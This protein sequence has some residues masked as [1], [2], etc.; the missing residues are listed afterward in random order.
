MGKSVLVVAAH[1]DDE[2][3]GCGA[4]I[5]KHV[6]SGD[7]VTIIFMTDGVGSRLADSAQ[8]SQRNQAKEKALQVLGVATSYQF[9][10]PDNAMD[11]VSLFEVVRLVEDVIDKVKPQIIYTHFHG[12]VN[13][14]H[15]ICFEA[16]M[17]ATRPVPNQCVKEIY[18]FEV[19]S[20]TEWQIKPDV[21]FTPQMY[22]D[23]SDCFEDKKI[24]LEAYNDEM[25][26][27]PHSRSF[28]HVEILGQHRGHTVGVKYAEAFMT[29]RILKDLL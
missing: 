3:L 20:S 18:G 11:S 9:D 8:V 15:R 16:V 4:T 12:D 24:A 1:A 22:V 19:L 28:E 2:V 7:Q 27:S 23:V 14:D 29:Y 26:D 6:D 17:T 13:V 10:F 25:R 5:K 21:A